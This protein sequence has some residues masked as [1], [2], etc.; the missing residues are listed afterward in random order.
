M[1]SP[2]CLDGRLPSSL[3]DS[4]ALSLVGDG[5]DTTSETIVV[6]AVPIVLVDGVDVGLV[7]GFDVGLGDGGEVKIS[8][9]ELSWF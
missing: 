3:I 2:Y 9:D 5:T 4:L 6:L 7:E 8:F 1:R